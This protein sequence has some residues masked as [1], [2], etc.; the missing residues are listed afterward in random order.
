ML[1]YKNQIR[2]TR[3]EFA[4]LAQLAAA[5]GRRLAPIRTTDDYFAATLATMDDALLDEIE[6]IMDRVFARHA[7]DA[8]A[9]GEG[10]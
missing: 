2:L 10:N 7:K 4:E 5:Q 8:P 9:E 6:A 1:Q 3:A